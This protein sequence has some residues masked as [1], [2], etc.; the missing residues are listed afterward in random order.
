MA[1]NSYPS[2]RSEQAPRPRELG[3][4]DCRWKDE[5]SWVG[6]GRGTDLYDLMST[7]DELEVVPLQEPR[8]NISSKLIESKDE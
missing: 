1:K 8:D 5:L 2:C 4:Q 3:Q 6:V 7:A